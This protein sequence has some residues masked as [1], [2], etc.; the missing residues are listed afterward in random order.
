MLNIC[1]LNLNPERRVII[2]SDIHASLALFKNLLEKVQ[3]TKDDYLFI[4]GDLCE[5]GLRS[6]ELVRYVKWMTEQ[7]KD[8]FVTKGNCDILY[9][10]ALAGNENI[11]PY[12]KKHKHSFLNEMLKERH[13][14]LED[15]NDMKELAQFY[16][17]YYKEEIDWIES[18]PIAFETEHFI[19]IH[20]GIEN[21]ADWKETEESFAL[22]IDSFLDKGHQMRKNVIVGHWPAVNYRF[23]ME[24]SNNPFI[25]QEKKIIAIDGGN[26]I[27]KDGQLNALIFANNQFS[28]EFVDEVKEERKV[29]MEYADETNRVG[30]VTWPNYEMLVIERETYFTLCENVKLGYKQWIKNEYLVEREDGVY[31]KDDLS[32][33]FL[34]VKIDE[35]V[36]V[37]DAEQSGYTLV[38]KKNGLV[39]WIPSE[40]I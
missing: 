21:R 1:Q 24:S 29:K 20:A 10:Y 28:Y 23:Q 34:S 22:S 12:M 32:T 17:S 36:N 9:R 40:I 5:K 38:K 11:I 16:M 25:D 39:G 26:Q 2:L 31:C 8:V 27:K 3:Y 14:I 19:L 35:R 7:S 4:N 18:L 33:T 13:Q 6:L 15:F 30:T 37:L